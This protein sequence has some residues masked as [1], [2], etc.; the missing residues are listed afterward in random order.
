LCCWLGLPLHTCPTKS[1]AVGSSGS[2]ALIFAEGDSSGNPLAVVKS[3][4]FD[5]NSD[6][7]FSELVSA[8]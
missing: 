5:L 8:G 3:T 4:S 7:L 1:Y 6:A 2:D